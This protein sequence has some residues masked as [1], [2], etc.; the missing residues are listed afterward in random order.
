MLPMCPTFFFYDDQLWGDGAAAV[1]GTLCSG[2]AQV[3]TEPAAR[4]R[5]DKDL[6]S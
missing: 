6:S 1:C 3:N 5:T 2:E 4:L